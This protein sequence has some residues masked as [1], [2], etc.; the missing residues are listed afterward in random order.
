MSATEHRPGGRDAVDHDG[1]LRVLRPADGSVIG[2]VPVHGSSEVRDSVERCRRVQAGWASLAVGDRLRRLDRLHDVIGDCADEVAGTVADETGKPEIEALA[3]VVTSLDLLG[4]Y[5]RRAEEVLEPRDAETGWLRG[6][7]AR[8]ERQPY[9][10][11]GVVTPW[12]Y[13]F[14]LAL[15]AVLGALAGGNG[16]VLKP[17]EHT[18]LS[19]MLVQELAERA[20]LPDGLVEVV[21]GGPR[22]GAALVRAEPDRLVFIGSPS[23]GREVAAAAAERLIPVSLELGGKGAALVLED[24]DLER[25]TRGVIFGAFY[26]AGQT[27]IATEWVFVE[28][29]I[30]DVFVEA[31]AE[32]VGEL[33]IGSVGERDVGPLTI[34]SQL[35]VVEEQVAD[36]VEKGARVVEG[37]ARIDPAANVYRPTVLA[38]VDSS[39]R[40]MREETFGPVLPICRVR[41]EREAVELANASEFGLFASVWTG[42]WDRGERIARRLRAGAVSVNDVLTPYVMPSLPVGGVGRSGWGR[43]RGLEGLRELTRT[44]SVLVNR[45]GLRRDPWWFPYG[46]GTRRLVRALLEFRRTGGLR[47]IWNG[48]AAWL[49]RRP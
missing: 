23:T 30:H 6:R 40:V 7:R 10:V 37:G 36:A 31:V 41:D 45:L 12:N 47:G 15:D 19:G 34:R 8:I 3:E 26:N 5:V 11:V 35:G 18:P 46:P 27:C 29:A 17:S 16:V 14:S 21:T 1:I 43:L 42:D 9:G 32:R 33:R 20:G 22:T 2:T 48:L 28:D 13:P 49:G 4:F 24:A 44:R 38:D 39:M 25:A